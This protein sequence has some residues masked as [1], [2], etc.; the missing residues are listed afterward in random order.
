MTDITHVL[1][2]LAIAPRKVRLVADQLRYQEVDAALAVLPLVIK[3]AALPM[4]KALAAAK[5][6]AIDNGLDA[7]TLIVQ[8][9][10][11]DEGRK[12]KRAV[13]NSRGRVSVRQKVASHVHIVLRGEMATKTPA[14]A[15]RAAKTTTEEVAATEPAKA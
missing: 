10:W 15:K 1:H 4:K 14:P 12:L 7:S 5:Q 9:I 6:Q 13:P 8:R 3:R 11:V 2:N